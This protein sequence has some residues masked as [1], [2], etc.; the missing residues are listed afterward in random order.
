[1]EGGNVQNTQA[2]YIRLTQVIG[3]N[4]KKINENI[5]ELNKLT[6]DYKQSNYGN[7]DLWSRL[8]QRQRHTSGVVVSTSKHFKTLKSLAVAPTESDQ[9]QRKTQT[10]RLAKDFEECVNSFK[11]T[12]KEI[13]SIEKE[14]LSKARAQSAAADT[15]NPY[16]DPTTGDIQLQ[17]QQ[18][19]IGAEEL[20]RIKQRQDDFLKLEE[21]IMAVNEIFNDLA[22]MVEE[23]GTVI[24]RIADHVEAAE[25]R[26]TT[27]NEQLVQAKENKKK[28]MKKKICCG[29][30]IGVAII[31]LILAIYFS[32][33]K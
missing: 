7:G 18:P 19:L 28:S 23:Q 16:V 25:I 29:S 3:S 10:E 32:I 9:R 33:P 14:A 20:E 30:I 5:P 21:D 2:Q 31:I 13:S 6:Q 11:L 12:Q 27:G 24:D 15:D 4:V 1:M 26:V 17:Q 8:Q 22:L